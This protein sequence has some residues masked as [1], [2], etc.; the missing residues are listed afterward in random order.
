[1]SMKQHSAAVQHRLHLQQEQHAS[2][3]SK[4]LLARFLFDHV[5]L[6]SCSHR[7]R[8][9]P[10]PA[11]PTPVA[12]EGSE[13]GELEAVMHASIANYMSSFS[14]WTGV[15]SRGVGGGAYVSP[16]HQQAVQSW[17]S[18]HTA[19]WRLVLP[20]LEQL[21]KGRNYQVGWCLLLLY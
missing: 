16:E 15:K 20:A 14:K 8:P 17:H 18:G 9:P 6:V 3:L 12:K 4:Q 11:P 19:A 1:M 5:R 2:V 21:R 7:L 10:A 13:V